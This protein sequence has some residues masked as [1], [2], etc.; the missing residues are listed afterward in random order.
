[1]KLNDLAGLLSAEGGVSIAA[2]ITG[3]TSDS[4]K[5]AP[6]M[7]FVAVAGSRADGASY[8]SDAARRG[9][10]AIVAAKNAVLDAQTA[11][12]LL[13]DDPR[14]ALAMLAAKIFPRQPETM[15]AVTGTSGKTS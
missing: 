15:V 1:M 9:A 11:P 12:L 2:E 7:I 8:A 4:R 14:L 13:V 6:G 5:V 10:A 3:V